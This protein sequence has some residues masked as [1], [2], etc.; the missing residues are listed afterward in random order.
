MSRRRFTTLLLMSTSV[1]MAASCSPTVVLP[2][3]VPSTVP[4]TAPSTAAGSPA[5][6]GKTSVSPDTSANA[7]P[8]APPGFPRLV[9]HRG[10]T[11]DRPENTL[12]AIETAL[13]NGAD[14]IWL[15]VQLSADDVPVLYRPA[16]LSS[17]TEGKGPVAGM[18]FAQLQQLN[19]GW[20]FTGPVATQP[21][22]YPYRT[23]P[24]RIPSL[25]E[26]LQRIP[27]AVPVVL[28]M[29]ALPAA[30]QTVAVAKVLD[31]ERAWGRVLIYSTEADYQRTFGSYPRARLFESRDATRQRL[32]DMTLGGRCDAPGNGTWA[33]F[34]LRRKVTVTETFTLG[35]GETTTNAAFW[36]ARTVACYRSRSAVNLV[37]F[38]V[39]DEAG[40][41]EAM[42][43]GVD[44]VMVDSPTRMRAIRARLKTLPA[45]CVRDAASALNTPGAPVTPNR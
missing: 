1:T 32:V 43:L 35:K 16:D 31:A 45:P 3:A 39:N 5:P 30:A 33:G 37:A 28:D 34:E 42:R 26:A 7:S 44:A 10:G 17:L 14:M 2:A 18:T 15:T 22:I 6:S 20:N 12:L 8:Q 19:A 9:A 23:R 24:V 40:Y 11:Q 21:P 29:K 25:R 38:G 4:S 36:N 41:C 27:D 13:A